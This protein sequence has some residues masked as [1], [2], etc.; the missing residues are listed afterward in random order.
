MQEIVAEVVVDTDEILK[1]TTRV[2]TTLRQV[3]EE[4]II[5]GGAVEVILIEKLGE[6]VKWVGAEVDTKTVGEEELE[7]PIMMGQDLLPLMTIQVK[8][9][10]HPESMVKL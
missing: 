3:E 9:I 5:K 2:T 8:Q 10:L 7:I 4:G 6:I 1:T